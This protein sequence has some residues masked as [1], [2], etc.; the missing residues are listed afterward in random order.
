MDANGSILLILFLFRFRDDVK[1]CLFPLDPEDDA[2][3]IVVAVD[4]DDNDDDREAR[5][6]KGILTISSI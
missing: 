4:S 1:Y 3:Y 5:K 6:V 2:E